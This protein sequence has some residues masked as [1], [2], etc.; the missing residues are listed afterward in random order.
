LTADH[1]ALVWT[2]FAD[3]QPFNLEVDYATVTP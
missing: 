2:G 3:S 1:G